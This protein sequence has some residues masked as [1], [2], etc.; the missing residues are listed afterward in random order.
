AGGEWE[1]YSLF[2]LFAER[3]NGVFAFGQNTP[4]NRNAYN[5]LM[6]RDAFV[7]YRNAPSNNANDIAA[8]WGSNKL[9]LFVQDQWQIHPD[10]RLDLGVRYERFVQDDKPAA[11]QIFQTTYGFNS[12]NNLDGK[13]LIQPRLG[14]EYK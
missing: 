5:D 8:A 12:D 3:T 4:V 13:D 9:A 1:D 10:L 11:S 6:N 14:F 2:N 7:L